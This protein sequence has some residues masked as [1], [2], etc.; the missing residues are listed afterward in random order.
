[1]AASEIYVLYPGFM[2]FY[3]VYTLMPTLHSM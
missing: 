2:L 3:P 1:M